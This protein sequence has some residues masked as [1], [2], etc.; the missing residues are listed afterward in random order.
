MNRISH[1]IHACTS[2]SAVP[3]KNTVAANIKHNKYFL[4]KCS[5]YIMLH[6]VDTCTCT[7]LKLWRSID[8]L[9]IS[10]FLFSGTELG[11]LQ[12]LFDSKV[13]LQVNCTDVPQV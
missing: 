2:S 1:N 7:P 10:A 6:I 9:L 13:L 5:M 12:T 11:R 3:S 8:R 4:L